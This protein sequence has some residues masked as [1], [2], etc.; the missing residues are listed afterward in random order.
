MQAGHQLL[1]FLNGTETGLTFWLDC[2]HGVSSVNTL[3]IMQ[4]CYRSCYQVII[5]ATWYGVENL[6][7]F[8][9]II[10]VMM[11]VFFRYGFV[12]F[13]QLEDA[14]KLVQKEVSWLIATPAVDS[15][16]ICHSLIWKSCFSLIFIFQS[17][18]KSLGQHKLWY[19]AA[20]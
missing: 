12:T 4:Q 9:M 6:W 8:L 18:S 15:N 7:K 13:V 11:V 1:I 2:T 19:F 16:I 10:L 3:C 20:S 5:A 14:E 17:L